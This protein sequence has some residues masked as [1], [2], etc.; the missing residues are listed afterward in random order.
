MYRPY[1]EQNRQLVLYGEI[2]TK[3]YL[4]RLTANK[5][6]LFTE[7]CDR[8]SASFC[9]HGRYSWRQRP[10]LSDG[11]DTGRSRNTAGRRGPD[12]SDVF[13]PAK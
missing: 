3:K 1:T 5:Y 6:I 2:T 11:K 4:S 13:A 12:L 7:I 10:L 8:Y 9:L